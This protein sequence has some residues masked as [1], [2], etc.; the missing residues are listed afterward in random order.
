MIALFDPY[1]LSLTSSG[2]LQFLITDAFNNM[3]TLLSPLPLPTNAILHIAGT[4]NNATGQQ[5]LFI[6]GVQVASTTT[7]IRPFGALDPSFYA[8]SG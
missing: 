3:S 1:R 5:L 8:V 2:Q 4:L 6:N 7:T